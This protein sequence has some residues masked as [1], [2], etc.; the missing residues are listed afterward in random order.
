MA[1]I[2]VSS[3]GGQYRVVRDINNDAEFSVYS[4]AV[5]LAEVTARKLGPSA[6]VL[7]TEVVA[8][9]T[10][11]EPQFVLSKKEKSIEVVEG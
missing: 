11:P 10:I 3:S 8:T 2:V 7:I 6:T 9:G 1:F 5:A 4:S